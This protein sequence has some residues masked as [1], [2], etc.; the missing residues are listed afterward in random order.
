ME[1]LW[2]D[3]PD[4]E[5]YY[6][7][8]NLGRIR[9]VD[10]YVKYKNT[11]GVALRKG[12]ILSPKTSKKGYLETTLMK[13]GKNYYKRI[14]QLIASAFLPNPNNYPYINHINENKKD[15]RVE[16]LEWC[17]PKYNTEVYHK[18]RIKLY[19]YTLDGE[20]IEVWNSIT[21]AAESLQGDK[22]GIHHCC[23][24]RISNGNSKKTY[25]GYI[26]SYSPLSS[27]E[28]QRRAT[29]E[30]LVRVIQLDL[31]GNILRS[32]NSTTEAAKAVG[33][34]P[35]AITMACNGLR[36]TIKGYQWRKN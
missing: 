30:G 27:D 1:E 25:L 11:D 31:N 14:H 8:S 21:K 29:N 15:N 5:G 12:K 18:S 10:R 7:A 2:K 4:F 23:V 26:W 35:S 36:K 24:G 17:T 20:L 6:Q 19:Q 13:E 28:L 32:Y 22:G 34:N 33:C 9:S 16:N 3:I